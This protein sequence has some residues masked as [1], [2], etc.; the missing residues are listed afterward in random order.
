MRGLDV[1]GVVAAQSLMLLERSMPCSC[2]CPS[3]S[4]APSPAAP[5]PVPFPARRRSFPPPTS[6]MASPSDGLA[7]QCF[8]GLTFFARNGESA[9]Q[10]ACR[11][12]TPRAPSTWSP[13]RT[14]SATPSP[15]SQPRCGTCRWMAAAN[16]VRGGGRASGAPPWFL[17]P[18][19]GL[20]MGC[21]LP[22]LLFVVV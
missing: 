11:V 9:A 21:P 1:D 22:F 18:C 12:C 16:A 3:S 15:R 14:S 4:A 5:A 2:S 7:R 13:T 8:R 10:Q 19:R 6:G 17:S 20:F